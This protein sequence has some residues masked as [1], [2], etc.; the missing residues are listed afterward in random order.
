MMGDRKNAGTWMFILGPT[1]SSV[2][3]RKGRLAGAPQRVSISANERGSKKEEAL[4]KFGQGI[5]LRGDVKRH[6][7]SN[8]DGLAERPESEKVVPLPKRGSNIDKLLRRLPPPVKRT[9]RFPHH[10]GGPIADL[11][12]GIVREAW[13]SGKNTSVKDVQ[14]APKHELQKRAKTP[15]KGTLVAL[16]ALE[17]QIDSP[18]AES[19]KMIQQRDK[20]VEKVE[21]CALSPN[22]SGAALTTM[23]GGYRYMLKISSR[24]T[25]NRSGR[26]QSAALPCRETLAL[27]RRPSSGPG[28]KP[29]SIN[30][31]SA[32]TSCPTDRS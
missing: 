13:A 18:Y 14:C 25:G 9:D 31:V 7:A 8:G 12:K 29:L 10:Q 30:V 2:T 15:V 32:S 23:P 5:R 4:G 1:A 26:P 17:K 24:Q 3:A 16:K 28:T 21:V 6:C 20:Y 27:P 22:S 19:L 11:R